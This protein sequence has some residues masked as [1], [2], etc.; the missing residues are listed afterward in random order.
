MFLTLGQGFPEEGGQQ[1]GV[2]NNM[3]PGK[4]ETLCHSQLSSHVIDYEDLRT[5]C[6]SAC[7]SGQAPVFVFVF[8]FFPSDDSDGTSRKRGKPVFPVGSL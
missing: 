6:E 2:K 1:K 7:L 4:K 5:G 8:F 3:I